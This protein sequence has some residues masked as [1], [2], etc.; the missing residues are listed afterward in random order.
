ML[1]SIDIRKVKSYQSEQ[2]THHLI[3]IE[4]EITATFELIKILHL[5]NAQNSW[6]LL[7]A[8]DH[9]PSK[10]LLDSCSINKE[11]L[12]VI[13]Q[14]HLS[15]FDYV[16]NSALNNGNFSAVITWTNMLNQKQLQLI[17][18]K[19]QTTNTHLYCFV[20]KLTQLNPLKLQ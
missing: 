10:S 19:Y 14:K 13:R 1:Q 9:V 17:A 20:E 15:N 5:Y 12:L 6:T 16:L 2:A 8:P 3:E 11:K 7:I 4:D 18:N